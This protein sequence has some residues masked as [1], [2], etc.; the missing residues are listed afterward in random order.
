M[1]R[2]SETMAITLGIDLGTTTITA[3]A[4]DLARGD[5][6]ACCT[7][8]ND[9]E[10]TA[11]ADKERGRSEWDAEKIAA[12]GCS[13]LRSVAESVGAR[14][15]EIVGLG[16]TGQ[17]HGVVVTDRRQTPL[18][19]LVNWQD[20]RGE[21]TLPG[22]DRT[23]VE[24]A[25]ALA[26]PE[27]PARTGCR[28]SAGYLGVTLYWLKQNGL[29]PPAGVACLVTDYFASR[30]T[31]AEPVTDPT[32]AAS[33]GL[34][35]VAARDWDPALL[36]ALGLPAALFPEV[37]EAGDPLGTLSESAA[38]ATGLPAGLPVFVGLGDNQAS[39]VGSVADRHSTVLVNV[40][41]G[42]QVGAFSNTFV[43]EPPLEVRPF[44]RGGYLLVEA[45]LCG[46][47]SYAALEGFFRQVGAELLDR[48]RDDRVY[49]AMNRL[50]ARAP[51]GAD[52]LRC[53]PF[54]TG[55]RAE[56]ERRA[57]WTGVSARNFTPANMTR[58]LLEG[59]ASAFR[60]GYDRIR[61]V[62]GFSPT[63]LVGA[64]NG[65]RENSV[66]AGIV[67]EEFGLPMVFPRHHEEAAYGAALVA[68]VGAGT[69]PDL[70][71]AGKLLRYER[72]TG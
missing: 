71:A 45:G 21:E 58:A 15:A 42:G 20:R 28:L 5:L 25:V 34:F 6:V 52:G 36:E 9:A 2:T 30:L 29:L 50:A 1:R 61:E 48:Q 64:G 59:M 8:P 63:H 40:G 44:P 10:T 67:A 31:D 16:V 43:F 68:A 55:T 7:R 62:T 65:L 56:P 11:A 53:E 47:R 39:F 69:F 70:D 12:I 46:G 14:R 27:A 51:P 23:C 3:L 4:L 22:G 38:D 18:T 32:M 13:A 33:S 17:Q 72:A 26:G 66:L 41:T 19:P 57:T 24:A 49:E 60:Y 37:R 54:F 35:D